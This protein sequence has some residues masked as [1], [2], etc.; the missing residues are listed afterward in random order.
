[1]H[2]YIYFLFNCMLWFVAAHFSLS[3]L[4]F[5][6]RIILLSVC[7]SA[8]LGR[9]GLDQTVC[10][11]FCLSVRP[12]IWAG[13]DWIRLGK[14]ACASVIFDHNYVTGHCACQTL[15]P[16]DTL[17]PHFVVATPHGGGADFEAPP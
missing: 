14:I 2:V 12:P 6:F 5:L 15:W 3:S 7:P 13:P 17:L 4:F 11:S 9:T 8:H 10:V 16:K 1:M